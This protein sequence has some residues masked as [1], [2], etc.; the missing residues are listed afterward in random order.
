MRG[1]PTHA[2]FLEGVLEDVENTLGDTP[3]ESQVVKPPEVSDFRLIIPFLGSPHD[4]AVMRV[5]GMSEGA[6]GGHHRSL[7]FPFVISGL[8]EVVDRSGRPSGI[9]A[10]KT[11][12]PFFICK[13][14]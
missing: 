8:P 5:N 3:T 4:V 11:T 14:S 9:I 12:I 7:L 10:E 1:L 6:A 2:C 13:E